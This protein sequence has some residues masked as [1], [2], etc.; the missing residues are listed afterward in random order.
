MCHEHD[1]PHLASNRNPN[2]TPNTN[3]QVPA[4]VLANLCVAYIMTNKNADAEDLMKH[5]ERDED[6]MAFQDKQFYHLCIVN[7]AIGTLYCA[8]GN[9]EFGI[10]RITKALE[11][12]ER[13]LSADTWHYAKRCFVAMADNLA[14]HMIVVKDATMGEILA[15]LEDAEKAG[16]GKY[17][18]FDESAVEDRRTISSEARRLLQVFLRLRNE[19]TV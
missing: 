18:T 1:Y 4:I 11:P 15:F 10:L 19:D 5:I 16:R 13:R 17:T 14:K 2:L 6:R 12:M 9:F 3:F 7:L 8:K